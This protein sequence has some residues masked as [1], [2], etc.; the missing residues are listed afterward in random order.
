MTIY[1][2]GE[3]HNVF[4]CSICRQGTLKARHEQV[5]LSEDSI[6]EESPFRLSWKTGNRVTIAV[7]INRKNVKERRCIS[8]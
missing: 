4:I 5:F 1:Y 7:N 3:D 6:T 8:K 2:L